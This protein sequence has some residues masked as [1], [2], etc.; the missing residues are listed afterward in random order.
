M[1]PLN[2]S[3]VTK[4]RN[5]RAKELVEKREGTRSDLCPPAAARTLMAVSVLREKVLKPILAG[6]TSS[7][8]PA[9][10]SNPLDQHDATLQ[11]DLRQLMA[12]LGLAL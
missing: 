4:R 7:S 1:V 3:E 8:Q 12:T 2:D 5:L 6:L 10:P 9:P 11:S